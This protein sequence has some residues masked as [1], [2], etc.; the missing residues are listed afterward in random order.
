MDRKSSFNKQST[1]KSQNS[2]ECGN[3]K[4]AFSKL[5]LERHQKFCLKKLEDCIYC[6][7]KFPKQSMR[8]HMNDCQAKRDCA[9]SQQATRGKP[10]TTNMSNNNN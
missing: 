3:C 5:D 6:K 4:Q 2:T 10:T 8:E 7:R 1:L 9:S